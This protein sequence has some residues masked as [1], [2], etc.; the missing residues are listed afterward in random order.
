MGLQDCKFTFIYD[1]M[2][3]CLYTQMLNEN[4]CQSQLAQ[5]ERDFLTWQLVVCKNIFVLMS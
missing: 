5:Q 1:T 4:D 3:S 2:N